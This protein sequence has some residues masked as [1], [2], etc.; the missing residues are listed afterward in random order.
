MV[1]GSLVEEK[2]APE[3]IEEKEKKKGRKYAQEDQA[4]DTMLNQREDY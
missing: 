3:A 2:D 4:L 1:I